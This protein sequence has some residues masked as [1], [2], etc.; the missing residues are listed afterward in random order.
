MSKTTKGKNRLGRSLRI[1]VLEPRLAL[2]GVVISEFLASNSHGLTDEDGDASDWIELHNTGSETVSLDGWYLTDSASNLMHWQLPD[3]DLAPDGYLVVFASNKNRAV[4]GQELHTNFAIS[5]G[6]EYLALVMPNGM[7]VA[8]QYSPAFPEQRTDISYGLGQ[9]AAEFQFIVPGSSAHTIV[10]TNSSYDAVWSSPAYTPDANWSVGP[11]GIGFGETIPGFA[12][13]NYKAAPDIDVSSVLVAEEIPGDPTKF[14]NL[15]AGNYNVINFHGSGT[16]SGYY[17]TNAPFPGGQINVDVDHFV[18]VVDAM[19]T[20]PTAGSWTFGVRSDDGFRLDIGDFTSAFT[21]PRGPGDT[22]ATFTFDAAGDYPLQLIYFE[23]AGGA[24]LEFFAAQGTHASWNGTN[25]RLVGNTAGGGLAVKS[26]PESSDGYSIQEFVSTDVGNLMRNVNSSFYTRIPFH[27]DNP[28]PLEQLVLRMKYDDAFIATIN[29]VEVARRNVTGS[30]QWNKVANGARSLDDALTYENIDITE[31]LS[32]LQPGENL[33]AIQ[34]INLSAS[35]PDVLILPE[36]VGYYDLALGEAYFATPTPGAPNAPGYLG[37]VDK[38]EFSVDHGFYFDPFHVEI[39]VGT[40]DA[41]IYYTTNGA[42]PTPAIGTLYTGPIDVSGTTV[43]RAAAFRPGYLPNNASTQTYI[44]LQDVL[45]QSSTPPP[46]WPTGTVNGQVHDYAMDPNIVNHAVWGP[47]LIDALQSIPTY[48]IVTDLPNLFHPATGI[49]VNAQQRGREWE[50]ATSIEL[51]HPDGTSGF[52]LDAGLRIRGGW[53]RS[54]SNP[55]HAFRLYFRNEYEGPLQ[56]AVFGDEGPDI[57]HRLDLRTSQNYSWSFSDGV[58]MTMVRDIFSRDTMRDLGQHYSRGDFAFLYVNGQFW[59]I[60]QTEERKEENFAATYLGGDKDEYDVIKAEPGPY[61]VEVSNGNLDAFQ[62]LWTLA[63]SVAAASTQVQRYE[64]FMQMQGFNSDGSR[65]LA[66]P[67]LLDTQNLIDYM[68]VILHSGNRD[69]PLTIST[70]GINNWYGIRNRNGET[71][72][73]FFVHDSEHTLLNVNE[74]R[75]GPYSTGSTFDRANPQWIHQQLMYSDEYRMQFADRVQEVMFNDGPLTTAANL[76]RHAART[77]EIGLAIIAESARWGDSKQFPAYTKNTWLSAINTVN[78]IIAG[79]NAVVI[80]QFRNTRTLNNALAPLFPLLDAPLFNQFGGTVDP[81]FQLTLSK[82]G[83]SPGS[84]TIY[85]TLDGSDPRLVHGGLNPAAI[86]YAGSITIDD[87]T[88]VRARIRDGSNWS[89]IVDATF[90]VTQSFTPGDYDENGVI[91]DFDYQFWRASFGQSIAAGTGADGNGDGFINAADY[92]LWRKN[93]PPKFYSFDALDQA[94]TQDFNVFRGTEATLTNHFTIVVDG[95]TNVFRGVFDETTDSAASFTGIKA[96]TSGGNDYSLAWRESTGPAA[97]DDA[98]VLFAFVNNTGEP[99]THF[100]VS[101]DVEA[102]V[103]GRRVNQ[104]RFKYDIYEDSSASQAAEGRNAFETD[105]FATVNPN[106]TLIDAN[107]EQFKLDG[108]AEANRVTVSGLVDLTTVPLDEL[109]PAAGVFGALMPGQVAY[110]RW[111]IS[112]LPEDEGNRS[113]LG[114]DNI[115][116]TPV[117]PG[118]GFAFVAASVAEPAAVL[119]V[120]SEAVAMLLPTTW[121]NR[122]SPRANTLSMP[123]KRFNAA[124][125]TRL[126]LSLAHHYQRPSTEEGQLRDKAHEAAWS[127]FRS[128]EGGFDEELCGLLAA[129]MRHRLSV[130]G[131]A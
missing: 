22:L 27:V 131:S 34:G 85:Y 4:A 83:G 35:D 38:A 24:M 42:T 20:I 48:S 64:I 95:G 110:F 121:P 21:A 57:F 29:G 98:R 119:T 43:L 56:Y 112:N 109:N 60:F 47:Q 99:I 16:D 124:P 31:F 86:A 74:N 122:L 28:A 115:S 100:N 6:G 5:A 105:I 77:D 71:G 102:W 104:V 7:T 19:V 23:R 62:D 128:L 51:I 84:A 54:P 8:H 76:A 96:A 118:F 41:Q 3:V 93:L 67:V 94:Y 90:P 14:T 37:F 66:Y 40:P 33:L 101:Y 130:E 11:T 17:G 72:F 53:S 106:H 46:G 78:N 30:S 55:K 68:L 125:D 127:S 12:V 91:N 92:V 1:E 97:L 13:R 82:P 126:L 2:A 26:Y 114:V 80:N 59:G 52:Q 65:N 81:G 50:R 75:T 108:K 87:A 25:F 129:G 58:R 45:Q 18:V 39:T 111:Q 117:A 116:I 123:V 63:N 15:V 9:I 103:N 120:E 107:G 79:R 70:T 44:F 113:A 69:A 10:P 88:Q 73:L 89:A 32:L 61:T 49:Y 36:L